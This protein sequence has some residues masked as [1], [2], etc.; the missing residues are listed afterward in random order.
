LIRFST[1]ARPE[2]RS[3]APAPEQRVEVD[4]DHQRLQQRRPQQR[5]RQP[6]RHHAVAR[7]RRRLPAAGQHLEQL[8]EDEGLREHDGVVDDLQ[9]PCGHQHA[10]VGAPEGLPEDALV[11]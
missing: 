4:V 3:R 9:K 10:A 8:L 1:P 5:K 6:Q 7:R 11:D 2:T